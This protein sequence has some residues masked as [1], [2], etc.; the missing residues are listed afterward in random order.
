MVRYDNIYRWECYQRTALTACGI[1]HVPPWSN[2]PGSGPHWHAL[3]DRVASAITVDAGS[4]ATHTVADTGYM[5]VLL[6]LI[7]RRTPV[8]RIAGT[9]RLAQRGADR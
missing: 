7:R 9:V 2:D 4:H 3:L 5:Y 6:A 8:V 1:S